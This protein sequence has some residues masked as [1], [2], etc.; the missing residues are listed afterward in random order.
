MTA[1]PS[2][3]TVS[4]VLGTVDE[5]P[6]E[7]VG[8]AIRLA[9]GSVRRHGDTTG[10]FQ[11]ASVT[12]LLSAVATLVAVEEG[13]VALDDPV[14][15]PGVTLRHLL[16]HA[17]G[18]SPE[19]ERLTDPGVR[20]IYANANYDLIGQHVEEATGLPFADYLR[21]GALAPL[22][23]ASTRLEGSPAFAGVGTVDDLVRLFAV[24]ADEVLLAPVTVAEAIS[25]QFPGLDGVL[26]GYGRQ[27]PNDWGLGFERRGTKAPHWTGPDHSADTVG[28][29]GA[30]G[31]FWW[32]DPSRRVG[33]VALT[34]RPFGEWAVRRWSEFNG[35]LLAAA[36]A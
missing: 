7:R 6:V 11:L 20:R 17:S 22:G 9:D 26:P 28:H 24:L 31:T 14:G 32:W 18:L 34:D 2:P 5:W 12:K 21:E 35:A 30:S 36:T 13:S 15:P 3:A 4:E 33:A 25:T 23:M 8:V 16:A 29:F 10:V 27:T 1:P 19:G